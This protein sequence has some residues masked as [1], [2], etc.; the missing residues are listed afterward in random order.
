VT[1]NNDENARLRSE[2]PVD[3]T[4]EKAILDVPLEPY[5]VRFWSIERR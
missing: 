5:G 2:R 1:A 3:L 4:P